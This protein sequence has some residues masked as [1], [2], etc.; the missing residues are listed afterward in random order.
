MERVN[1][2]TIPQQLQT[3]AEDR[4]TDIEPDQRLAVK[5]RFL[6]MAAGRELVVDAVSAETVGDSDVPRRIVLEPAG[7]T[8]AT[9]APRPV[10]C[11]GADLAAALSQGLLV[12]E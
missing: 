1:L 3:P 8:G 5:E 2:G 11:H 7:A 6:G 4:R 10:R 9:A 12:A